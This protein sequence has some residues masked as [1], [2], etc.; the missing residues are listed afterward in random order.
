MIKIQPTYHQGLE[1][2]QLSRLPFKQAISLNEWLPE[3]GIFKIFVDG[4]EIND[5]VSYDDYEFWFET[6]KTEYSFSSSLI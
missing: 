5:C 2:V 3:T 1:Y 4:E 6:T